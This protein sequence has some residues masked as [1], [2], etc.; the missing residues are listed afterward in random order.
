MKKAA[1]IFLKSRKFINAWFDKE[2]V[3]TPVGLPKAEAR[4]LLLAQ[5][6]QGDLAVV[7]H[8]PSNWEAGTLAL[9]CRSPL[10]DTL[11]TQGS[12]QRISSTYNWRADEAEMMEQLD[13]A[14]YVYEVKSITRLI[15]YH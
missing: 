4:N 15:F 8:Q 12:R 10:S 1:L 5:D 11:S 3:A 9:S 6:R 13:T 14:A 2:C 7:E